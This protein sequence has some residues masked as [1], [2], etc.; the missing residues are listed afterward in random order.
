MKFE[1]IPRNDDAERAVIGAVLVRSELCDDVATVLRPSDFYVDAHRRIFAR[2]VEMLAESKGADLIL[3]VQ[4][5]RESGELKEVGGEAYLA[6]LMESAQTTAHAVRYAEIVRDLSIKRRLIAASEKI[7]HDAESGENE[8]RELIARA[9]EKI[10]EV[11]ERGVDGT[12]KTAAEILPLVYS[13]LDARARGENLGLSTG[14]SELDKILGGLRNAEL[15]VVAARPSM[16]KTAFASN[17]ADF[18]AVEQRKPV[19]FFSLEMTETEL[20]T[21]MVCGRGRVCSE[22]LRSVLVG[23]ELSAFMSAGNEISAA[24]LVVSDAPSRT[25]AEIGAVARRTK[26]RDGL[27]LIVIDYLGL[28]EPDDPKAPRQEQ[29]AKIARRLKGLARELNVPVLCLA[30]LNRQAETTKDNRPRL[31]HLRESGAIEQDAD[32]VLFVHREEYYISKDEA[33]E[34]GLRGVAEIIV[35]KHRNGPTGTARLHW[36]GSY[37]QFSNIDYGYDGASGGYSEFDA[38]SGSGF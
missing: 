35:A 5:L 4:R 30:Q 24:P 10:F 25:V 15:I 9:E 6:E 2:L 36:E 27:G 28:I 11:G 32:V 31:S 20:I 16:G 14:F 22:S 7:L 21:R 8:A 26:R 1:K 18:V 23:S 19:L 34:K 29:V 12:T 37:T 3:L 38:Y 33:E 17:V 13:A